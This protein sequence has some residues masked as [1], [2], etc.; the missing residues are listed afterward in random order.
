MVSCFWGFCC[1]GNY[2]SN[3]TGNDSD[4]DGIGDTPFTI[5]DDEKDYY[6]LVDPFKYYL[7]N[8]SKLYFPSAPILTIK[9]QTPTNNTNIDLEW[10]E[11]TNKNG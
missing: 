7:I 1:V 2:W 9:T 4:G 3:Y 8:I 11:H 6:P 10:Y 5:L